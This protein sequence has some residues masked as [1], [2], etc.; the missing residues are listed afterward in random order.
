MSRLTMFVM[1]TAVA[2][3]LIASSVGA[4]SA[5]IPRLY[6]QIGPRKYLSTLKNA[7]GTIVMKV[8]RGTYV[9]VVRDRSRTCHFSLRGPNVD[10]VIT[11]DKFRGTK[12]FRIVLVPTPKG[13]NPYGYGCDRPGLEYTLTV[14]R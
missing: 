6:A 3:G 8:R 13:T 4:S 14:T 1:A 11:G 2:V 7:A 5:R 12:R 10:K 9:F